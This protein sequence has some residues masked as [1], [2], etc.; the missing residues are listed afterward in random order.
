MGEEIKSTKNWE[1]FKLHD[2]EFEGEEQFQ[3]NFIQA[4]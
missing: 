4:I 3:G 1:F 2:K